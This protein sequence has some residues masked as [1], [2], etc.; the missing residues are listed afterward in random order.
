MK[1]NQLK[2]ML[3]KEGEIAFSA[4]MGEY[5]KSIYKFKFDV[6]GYNNA[7]KYIE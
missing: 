1:Y 4:T 7:V 5:T 3:K 2:E 6:T